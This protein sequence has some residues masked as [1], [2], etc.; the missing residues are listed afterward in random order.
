MPG[1]P[2]DQ[3]GASGP[4]KLEGIKRRCK[5]LR[6]YLFTLINYSF[7]FPVRSHFLSLSLYLQVLPSTSFLS[8]LTICFSSFLFRKEHIS[9]VHQL[10]MAYQVAVRLGTFSPIKARQDNQIGKWVSKAGNRVIKSLI[11]LLKVPQN[12]KLHSCK[13]HAVPC[14]LSG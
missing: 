6:L 10:A 9:L 2:R 1:A 12:S 7:I 8:I 4:Q 14:K 5:P 11:S 13:I 3:K